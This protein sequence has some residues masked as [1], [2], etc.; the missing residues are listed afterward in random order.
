MLIRRL[1]GPRIGYCPQLVHGILL[2]WVE[3]KK[4][5]CFL[6]LKPERFKL[7][8]VH[9]LVVERKFKVVLNVVEGDQNELS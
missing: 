6:P 1:N 8:V 7:D 9:P 4:L 2:K 5:F 3:G